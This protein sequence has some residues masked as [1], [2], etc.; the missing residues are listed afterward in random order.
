MEVV[1]RG[2]TLARQHSTSA[3]AMLSPDTPSRLTRFVEHVGCG[4]VREAGSS[5]AVAGGGG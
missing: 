1:D 2:D 4:G 5:S 3:P